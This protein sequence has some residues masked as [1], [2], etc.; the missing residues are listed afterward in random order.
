MWFFLVSF[1]YITRYFLDLA[2]ERVIKICHFNLYKKFYRWSIVTSMVVDMHSTKVNFCFKNRFLWEQLNLNVIYEQSFLAVTR[3]INPKKGCTIICR[4]SK[5]LCPT[6]AGAPA[7]WRRRPATGGSA[8]KWCLSGAAEI[9]TLSHA[10]SHT[11]ARVR[12]AHTNYY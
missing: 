6:P 3:I 5:Q 12:T 8:T 10:L 1:Y 11:H 9:L 7:T 4:I 2:K